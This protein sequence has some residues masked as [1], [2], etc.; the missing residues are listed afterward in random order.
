[1][2]KLDVDTLPT[3]PA[4]PPAAG[5]DRAL[6]EDV[7]VVEGDVAGV[8]EGDV[9][10]LAA[11]PITANVS[12][13]ATIQAVVARTDPEEAEL[14][15]GF[16]SDRTSSV[17]TDSR[18]CPPKR[19]S[20]APVDGLPISMPPDCR[21]SMAMSPSAWTYAFSSNRTKTTTFPVNV[22]RTAGPGHVPP[23]LPGALIP[24]IPIGTG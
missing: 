5:P 24:S 12:A 13:A 2:V 9:A 20:P 11:S 19:A 15:P 10:Q 14:R 7:A 8:A 22:C 16:V 21:A 3:V 18:R 4:A 17:A 1:M 6:E 23:Q